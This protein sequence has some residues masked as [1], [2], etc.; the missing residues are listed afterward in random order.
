[1]NLE[2]E[3]NS[4]IRREDLSQIDYFES[5]V[6]KALERKVIDIDFINHIQIQLL[7]LLKIKIDKFNGIDNSS[8]SSDKA[9]V[10]MDSNIYTIGLYLKKFTPDE[11]I[12]KLQKEPIISMYDKGRKE[13]DKKLFVCKILHQKVLK[14]MITTQ[15]ETYNDTIIK[16]IKGF[17]KI[18]DPD[19]NARDMK[20]TADY[21]LYNN[22]IGKIEGVEFIEKYLESLY[23][24]NE[25]C[26]T[27]PNVEETLQRYSKGYKNLIINIFSVTLMTTL[28]KMLPKKEV[29]TKEEVYADILTAYKKLKI[30]NTRLN[31]YIEKGISEIQAEIYNRR[32]NY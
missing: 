24:E 14:N 2:I 27:I 4:V 9:K 8:I 20:I 23:Y 5:L 13:I 28:E 25:F 32:T 1:M 6:S 16:G 21:P 17:F 18:Y 31:Q 3:R 19:Y 30:Q 10:I 12:E 7:E 26:K 22:L 11:S 29:K 15:N